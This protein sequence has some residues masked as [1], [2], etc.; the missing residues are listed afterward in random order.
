MSDAAEVCDFI[1]ESC[2]LVIRIVFCVC[3]GVCVCEAVNVCLCA[4][5]CV[6]VCKGE[7]VC[8]CLYSSASLRKRDIEGSHFFFSSCVD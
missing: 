6:C 3:V 5:G 8:V 4:I 2:A 7:Y 1:M